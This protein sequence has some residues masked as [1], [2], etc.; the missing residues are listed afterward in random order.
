MSAAC[1]NFDDLIEINKPQVAEFQRLAEL[2]PDSDG[3]PES[4]PMSRQVH[5]VE[6]LLVQTYGIAS[7]LTKETGDLADIA[8]IWRNLASFCN[9][10]LQALSSLRKRFPSCGTPELYDLALDYK[11]AC[12]KRHHRVLQELSCQTIEFPKGIFPEPN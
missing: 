8:E 7:K 10:V 6:G 2:L 3:S 5:I 9:S 11:L 1:L 4:A 12:D